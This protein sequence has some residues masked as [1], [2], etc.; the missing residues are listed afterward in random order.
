MQFR[1]EMYNA[2]NHTQFDS[3]DTAAR[4]DNTPNSATFGQQT[5]KTFGQINGATNARVMQGSLRIS[6]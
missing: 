3:V 2:F 5:S 6:F 1:W 4:F